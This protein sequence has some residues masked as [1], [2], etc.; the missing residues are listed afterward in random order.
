[1]NWAIYRIHYGTDFLKQSIDSIIDSVDKVFVIY[2]LNPWVVE[3]TVTYLGEVYSMPKLQEDVPVFME[4]HYSNNKKV[5]WFNQE[6]STPTNQFRNYY[7]IC[8]EKEI[9]IN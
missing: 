9:I 8:V 2:S 7:D 1:M 4:K 5:E 3:G 6:V